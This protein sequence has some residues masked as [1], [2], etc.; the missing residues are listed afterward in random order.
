M[1]RPLLDKQSQLN[2][3]TRGQW[4][5]Y[6]SHRQEIER[7]LVPKDHTGRLCVLGAGNCN[8][9]DLNWLS[10]VYREIHLAD[11]DASALSRAVAFQKVGHITGLRLHAPIDLTGIGDIARNWKTTEP[12]V[13]QEQACLGNLAE[14]PARITADLGRDFNTVLSPCVLSQLLTPLREALGEDNAGFARL[15]AA[16]CEAHLKLMINLLASGGRGVFVCDVLSSTSFPEL[17]RVPKDRLGDFMRARISSGRYFLGLDPR[18]ILCLLRQHPQIAPHVT[19]VR[20][21][22]PWLWHLGL[23]RSFLVYGVCFR[24]GAM[25]SAVAMPRNLEFFM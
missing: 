14:A 13:P 2:R 6:A 1:P 5:L 8:D 19:D 25:P 17:S 16:L 20:P 3:S 18:S 24:R 23:D 7:L 4:P 12:A 9:L 22:S 21:V 15:R 11:I 10:R